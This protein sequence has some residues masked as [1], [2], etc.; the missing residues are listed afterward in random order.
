[1]E[2]GHFLKGKGCYAMSLSDGTYLTDKGTILSEEDAVL[3]DFHHTRCV[4]PE[5]R[6]VLTDMAKVKENH[7]SNLKKLEKLQNEANSLSENNKELR[8]KM[9]SLV[10]DMAVISEGAIK[11]NEVATYFLTRGCNK[12]PRAMG[13]VKV[14]M[15]RPYFVEDGNG[16]R[17]ITKEDAMN[18]L[19]DL[20]SDVEFE[21]SA[22]EI[23]LFME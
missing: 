7:L 14:N 4:K 21:A 13:I 6:A 9:L 1:M 16:K 17:E 10:L 18:I 3:F 5:L 22:G 19:R 11:H 20:N 12:L 15:R 23:V 2:K 8:D